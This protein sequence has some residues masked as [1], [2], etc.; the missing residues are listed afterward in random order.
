MVEARGR[1]R[2]NGRKR[3]KRMKRIVS[4]ILILVI[5]SVSIPAQERPFGRDE[6]DSLLGSGSS[7][8]R[9]RVIEIITAITRAADKEIRRT[10]EEAVKAAALQAEPERAYYKSMAESLRKEA[11][12]ASREKK[13]FR[14]LAAAEAGIIV[15]LSG[16][17]GLVKR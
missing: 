14:F 11:E 4:G 10:A 6:I 15:F 5:L 2:P 16:Y 17:A 9:E 1:T 8:A 13:L 7:F 3:K 12:R